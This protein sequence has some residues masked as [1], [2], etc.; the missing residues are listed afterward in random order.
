MAN[1]KWQHISEG[2]VQR[3]CE[4]HSHGPSTT[5][6]G[7]L[8]QC[9]TTLMVK[10]CFLQAVQL[11]LQ[12]LSSL[13]GANSTSRFSISGELAEDAFHS[14]TTS[15]IK[16]L[17]G[18]LKR[19]VFLFV[20]MIRRLHTE[21]LKVTHCFILSSKP[22][23]PIYVRQCTSLKFVCVARNYCWKSR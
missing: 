21:I 20:E 16:T 18:V 14:C 4:H 9:F 6:L 2:I 13:Q 10:K 1:Q 19:I 11:H 23:T 5:L 8:F 22:R 12:G 17:N 15:L 3:P 7:S